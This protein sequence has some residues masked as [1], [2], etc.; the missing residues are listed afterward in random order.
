MGVAIQRCFFQTCGLAVNGEV[1]CEQCV[2][3]RLKPFIDDMHGEDEMLFWPDLA[4]AHYARAT[5]DLFEEL[6]IPYVPV[7]QL[8]P[9][10]R[11]FIQWRIWGEY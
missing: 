8:L 4:S 6:E 10:S 11:N 7:R 2:R 9:T 3:E 1:Y 5:L